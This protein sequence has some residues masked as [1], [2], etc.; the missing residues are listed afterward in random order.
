MQKK[1]RADEDN[2]EA[3][4]KHQ[5][6][7]RFWSFIKSNRKDFSGVQSLRENGKMIEDEKA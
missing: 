4:P 6:M 2:N 5:G 3:M 7:K 1:T